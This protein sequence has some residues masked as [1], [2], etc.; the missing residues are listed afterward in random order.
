MTDLLQSRLRPEDFFAI[1]FIVFLLIPQSTILGRAEL[2]IG[3]FCLWLV[4]SW[5]PQH[6]STLRICSPVLLALGLQFF[7]YVVKSLAGNSFDFLKHDF[8][9]FVTIT[10]SLYLSSHYLLHAPVRFLTVRV[11]GLIGVAACITPAVIIAWQNPGVVRLTINRMN[12]EEGLRLRGQGVP[13][14]YL[15]YTFSMCTC[16]YMNFLKHLYGPVKYLFAGAICVFVIHVALSTLTLAVVLLAGVASIG[17]AYWFW[18]RPVQAAKI[19]ALALGA[20]LLLSFFSS[21]NLINSVTTKSQIEKV[22][23]KTERLF[24]GMLEGGIKEGDETGRGEKI[25]R[26]IETFLNYPV[27]GMPFGSKIKGLGIGGHSSLIDPLGMFGLL[28]Y[29]PMWTFYFILIRNSVKFPDPNT[30]HSQWRVPEVFAWCF[31]AIASFWNPTTFAVLPYALLFLTVVNPPEE[32]RSQ[33]L[34]L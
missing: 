28:G 8:K 19:L 6:A 22:T 27:F 9:G 26:G 20:F 13:S 32:R 17:S 11:W 33:S 1:A 21:K 4:F 14:Y 24:T 16:V 31:Y 29:I 18:K 15:I 3:F 5:G 2:S 25:D 23:S 7:V 10:L 34:Y 12:P 30:G